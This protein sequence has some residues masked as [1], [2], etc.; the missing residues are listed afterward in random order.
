MPPTIELV[1]VV[2]VPVTV[3]VDCDASPVVYLEVVKVVFPVRVGP[4]ENTRLDDV[5]PV[6][7][8]VE[9]VPVPPF[10]RGIT[11]VPEIVPLMTGDTNVLL[12]NV[13]VVL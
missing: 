13:S 3:V 8:A 11:V 4:L 9:P 2:L 5:L 1:N 7:P 10:A 6:V 12:F